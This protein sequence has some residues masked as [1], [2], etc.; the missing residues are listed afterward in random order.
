[1]LRN[2]VLSGEVLPN[3]RLVEADFARRLS[4]NRGSI[5]KALA[6]LEQEGLVVCERNRG[7]HVRLLTHAE[8]LEIFEVRGCLEVLLVQTAAVIATTDDLVL[9]DAQLRGARSALLDGDPVEVG[10][11][12]RKLREEIWR[13]SN[14]VLGTRLLAGLNAQLVRLWYRSVL[15]PGRIE[16]MVAD[17]QAIVAAIEARSPARAAEAMRTYHEGAIAALTRASRKATQ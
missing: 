14:N 17:L 15:M 4:T 6:R 1:M 9:L 3:E 8:A 10:A 2:M 7:A 5:R 11:H 13:I 16:A 12:S